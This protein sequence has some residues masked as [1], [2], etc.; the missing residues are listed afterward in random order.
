MSWTH[1]AVEAASDELLVFFRGGEFGAGYRG[2]ASVRGNMEI[3][4]DTMGVNFGPYL[5]R[6]KN[7]VQRNW[8]LVMPLSAQRPFFTQGKVSI[9]FRI[10]KNGNVDALTLESTSGRIDLDRAAQG[11]I[12]LSNPFEALPKEFEGA[13]LRIRF[14]F[15]YNPEKGEIPGGN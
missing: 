14:T 1:G 13:E 5:Q 4:S 15:Y 7:T 10:M 3:L 8:Y 11:G 6:V 12:T 2:T 9:I